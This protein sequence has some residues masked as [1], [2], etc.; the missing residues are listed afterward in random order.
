MHKIKEFDKTIE[1]IKGCDY[2]VECAKQMN[3]EEVEANKLLPE[4]LQKIKKKVGQHKANQLRD[5][6]AAFWGKLYL[7]YYGN[8]CHCTL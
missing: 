5:L 8:R 4:I 7:T 6:R 2:A 1:N 3:L